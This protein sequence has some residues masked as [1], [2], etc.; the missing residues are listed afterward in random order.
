MWKK[1]IIAPIPKIK[2]GL[3]CDPLNYRGISLI[4]TLG[5]A[6]SSFINTRIVKYCN[7]LDLICEEQNGF[8]AKR[9]CTDHIFVLNSIIRSRL[10]VNQ[11][12]FVAFVD[13]EKCFDSINRN[14]LLNRLL[15]FNI[16]GNLYF[17]IKSVYEENKACIS[18]LPRAEVPR[19]LDIVPLPPGPFY[20][21][22]ELFFY[23][24]IFQCI[25]NKIRLH[26]YQ[27]RLSNAER[28]SIVSLLDV[29]C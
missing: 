12:L 28:Q 2:S 20:I 6:F 7:M 17:C 15:E 13:M 22:I 8:R 23:S 3:N 29:K 25:L 1:A 27:R 26:L 10:L 24:A 11:S 9:S 21:K 14:L 18:I 5:K 4:S 16:D 19:D